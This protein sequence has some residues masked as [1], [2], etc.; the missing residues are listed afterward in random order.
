MKKDVANAKIFYNNSKLLALQVGDSSRAAA[1]DAALT[2]LQT[3]ITRQQLTEKKLVSSLHTSIESGD[4]QSELLNYQY[5]AD[6]YAS[7]KQFDKALAYTNQYYKINDSLESADVQ[8]QMKKM[9]GQY[10]LEKKEQEI[11]LLKKDQ[12]LTHLNLQRQKTFQFGAL[13]FLFLLVLIGLLAISRYR[14]VHNAKRQIEMEKMRNR[15]AQDLHDDIGSALSSINVLSNVALHQKDKEELLMKTNM[16]K[17][18][19]RSSAIM[20]SMDDIVWAINPQNDT[21][22]QLLFRMKEFAAEILEPLNINYAFDEQGDF[23]SIKLDI[24]KRKDLYL[25]FK[26]AINNAAK[27]SQCKNLR[28][29]LHEK[30]Q[31]LQ[32]EI[33]DDG[34]G[35]VE[36]RARNG[37]GLNNMRERTASMGANILIDS[38]VGKGTTIALDLPIT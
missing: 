19:E 23:S 10:N 26:E 32:M 9:E 28:I 35:F 38:A 18:K 8:L 4:K 7:T 15:I 1:A 36:E 14:I 25:L 13:L 2:A 17:I 11:A 3:T 16:Q 22:E 21:M 34:K 24:K 5:L 37:N 33:S 6:H 20:E 30:H 12:E 27:Y 29:N 31:H